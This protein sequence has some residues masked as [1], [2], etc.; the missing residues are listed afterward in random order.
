MQIVKKTVVRSAT[1]ERQLEPLA[2]NSVLR[3]FVDGA[4]WALARGC[5]PPGT[6]IKD[7]GEKVVRV[8]HFSP[9]P[10][11]F[12]KGTA[13]VFLIDEREKFAILEELL[14]PDEGE[15]V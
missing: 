3:D 11:G 8:G 10:F 5:M 13:L 1:L 4:E 7:D 15:I 2:S 9:V 14:F 12:L 6:D